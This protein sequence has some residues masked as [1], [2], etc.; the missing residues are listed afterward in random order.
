MIVRMAKVEILGPKD[1]LMAVLGLLRG[2]GAFQPD[3]GLMQVAA[4]GAETLA[5]GLVLSA[6]EIRERLFFENLQTRIRSLLTLLPDL[7]LA[8]AV[9]HPLPVV[10]VFDELVDRH[11]EEAEQFQ[12]RLEE[13]RLEEAGLAR[14]LV[15]W[16]TIEP[17]LADLPEE[18]DLEFFGITIHDARHLEGIRALLQER[19]YGQCQVSVATTPDGALVGLVA[20]SRQMAEQL[21][22]TMTD[23]KI[24][25]LSL[26][27]DLA[28]RSIPERILAL[29]HR[30]LDCQAAR[31]QVERS[32]ESLARR[33]LPSYRQVLAWLEERLALYRATATAY[34]TRQCFVVEGWMAASEVETLRADLSV[35]FAGQ[36]V[37]EQL[38]IL[39]EE[40]EQVPVVLHN[41]GYFAPFEVF[42]RLLPLPKYTSYDPTP[43]IGLFF[44]VLFGMIL[45]DIGYGLILLG[46]S[47]WLA[48][49]L[50]GHPLI[51]NLGKVLGVAAVYTLLFGVLFGELFGDLGEHWFNLS[52]LWVDRAHAIAPMIIFS[53]SV[54]VAHV[55]FGLGL[56]VWTDLRRQRGRE[57]L[58]KFLSLVLTL[59]TIL[60]LVAWLVPTPWLAVRPLLGGILLLLPLLVAIGGLLAPLELLKT[61]GNIVSYVRIMAI[62]L[63][64]VLLAVVANRLGGATGDVLAGLLVAGV[65]HAFNLLLGVFAPTVHSLR[66]HYVE[67]FSKFLDLGGR[68]FEPLNRDRT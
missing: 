8:A 22:M 15:F 68:R 44:P 9:L 25:E 6:E 36:V 14:D 3:P 13:L 57:A 66:L 62:G 12:V 65:L 7:S 49:G 63:C 34:E 32:L 11:L 33:W 27:E 40:L 28:G 60:L 10:D 2:R 50:K 53:I 21:R 23:E 64:S 54:G 39:T 37:L 4:K 17:M 55:L 18:S 52:P 5:R 38:E 58:V 20:T 43:F 56:G 35:Q 30:L 19:L 41:P 51:S 42:S 47:F 46:L 59:L 1:Q 29:R 61:F 24:P 16:E 45:G 67:F 48:R 26:P 31:E